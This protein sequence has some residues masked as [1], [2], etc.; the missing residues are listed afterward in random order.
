MQ[1]KPR[2]SRA[3]RRSE[4][5]DFDMTGSIPRLHRRLNP[6]PRNF[7]RAWLMGI[8]L[9]LSPGLSADEHVAVVASAAT[10]Y[11]Q[12]KFDGPKVRTETYVFMEGSFIP[13][14]TVDRSIERMPF[15]RIAEFLAPELARQQYLPAPEAK[16]ADLLIVVHWGTTSPRTSAA[17]MQGTTTINLDHTQERALND[18]INAQAAGGSDIMS[19]WLSTG[20]EIDRQAGFEQ[21]ERYTDNLDSDY[22]TANSAKLLGYSK[23][24]QQLEKNIFG[25]TEETTL[26]SD[27]ST[28]RYFIILKAYDLKAP[29]A[30]GQKRRA[31]WTAHLNMRSPG[32]NF[33]TALRKMGNVGAGYFGKSTDTVETRL[34]AVREGRVILGPLVIIEEDGK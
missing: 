30:A 13:G 7:V 24:L 19:A 1:R 31:V 23:S 22:T 29:L 10:A 26:R 20:S 18:E 8:A 32:K 34:P 9:I 2:E 14:Q 5:A 4:S 28:E 16:S 27:L 6:L 12:R 17:E 11:T 21:A 25:S 15:R 3:L 33:P